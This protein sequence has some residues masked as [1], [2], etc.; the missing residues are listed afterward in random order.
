[1]RL[2]PHAALLFVDFL[3]SPDGQKMFAEK[4]FYGSAAKDYGFERWYPEKGLSTAEYQERADQWLK[5]L[6]EITRK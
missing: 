1:M 6:R 5:L 2:T 4:L 3:I